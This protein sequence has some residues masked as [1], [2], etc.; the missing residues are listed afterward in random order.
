MEPLT[1]LRKL[2]MSQLQEKVDTVRND[3]RKL[4]VAHSLEPV[5]NPRQ[6]TKLR[7]HIAR[8]LTLISEARI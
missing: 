2:N 7:K 6:I 4:S 1:D 8:L 3:L 5:K